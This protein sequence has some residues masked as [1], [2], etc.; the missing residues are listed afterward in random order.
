MEGG[1]DLGGRGCYRFLKRRAK[2]DT[3]K[4]SSE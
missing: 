2:I 1:W 3:N 4:A